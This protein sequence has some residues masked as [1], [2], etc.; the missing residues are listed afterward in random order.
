MTMKNILTSSGSP[1]QVCTRAPRKSPLCC[2][3]QKIFPETDMT[4][5]PECDERLLV[6]SCHMT[7][8]ETKPH[9]RKRFSAESWTLSTPRGISH[10]SSGMWDGG[11]ELFGALSQETL[12][13]PTLENYTLHCIARSFLIQQRFDDQCGVRGGSY[14][15]KKVG[16][17]WSSPILDAV[18]RKPTVG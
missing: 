3:S 2:I 9:W 4:Q 5:V 6:C 1:R 16:W 7:R 11:D 13:L 12:G 10:M 15:S 8:T 14:C 17:L 18:L